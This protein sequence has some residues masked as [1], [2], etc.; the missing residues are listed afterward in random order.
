MDKR[1]LKYI[2]VTYL[3]TWIFWWADAILV[4]FTFFKESDILPMILFTLGGFGP[5][6]SACLCMKG[7]FSWKELRK[8]LT[9][10]KSKGVRYF[11]LFVIMEIIVFVLPSQDFIDSIKNADVSPMLIIA[12]VFLQAALFYGGNEEWG[13]RGTMQ[14]ILQQKLPYCFATL[15]VGIVWVC[16]HIPLWFI[17]GN[18]HQ[19]MSFIS[20]AIIGILLSYWLSAVYNTTGSVICCMIFHGLTNTLM[21]VLETEVNVIYVVGL[22]TLTGISILVSMIKL[23][24]DTQ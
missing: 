14:P 23:K 4:K 15:I 17:E 1:L 18:S 20:F 9:G 7:G 8:F 10:Y 21:G 2:S 3:I 13:W 16:W 11:L 24:P 19:S 5:T 6:I 12:I 22:I